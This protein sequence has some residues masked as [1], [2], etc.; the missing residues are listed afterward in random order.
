VGPGS[1]AT[2]SILKRSWT[3]GMQRRHHII[4]PRTGE[5]A[6]SN[7]LSVTV[8]AADI[9]SA[10]VYAKA[11]LIG[12]VGEASK[13]ASGRPDLQYVA[14]QADGATWGTPSIVENLNE[15]NFAYVQ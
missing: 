6:R 13:L 8:L 2:S 4:D 5:P 15:R 1:V 7:W 3:Q 14:V 11:L 10:E 9:M 12:G